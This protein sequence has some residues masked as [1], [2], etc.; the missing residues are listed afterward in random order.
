MPC[1]SEGRQMEFYQAST[2][3]LTAPHGD[4]SQVSAAHRVEDNISLTADPALI[5]L[6]EQKQ[7]EIARIRREI[8]ILRAA[9]PLLEGDPQSTDPSVR[10][11]FWDKKASLRMRYGTWLGPPKAG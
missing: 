3:N 1:L 11:D 8:Q 4:N 10:D 9:I 7:G 5:A 6:V 2:T